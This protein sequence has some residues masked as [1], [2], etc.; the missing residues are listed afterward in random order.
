M[1]ALARI[2]YYWGY[3]AVDVM[4]R[5]SQWEVMKEG[6][7]TMAGIF[8]RWA[9]EHRRMSIRKPANSSLPWDGRRESCDAFMQ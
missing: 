2:V 7:G 3:P 8:P 1:E 6:P 4:V 5:T 9:G